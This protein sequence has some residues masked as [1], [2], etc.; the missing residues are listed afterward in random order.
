MN[1]NRFETALL[2]QCKQIGVPAPSIQPGDVAGSF[3]RDKGSVEIYHDKDGRTVAE[4][5]RDFPPNGMPRKVVTEYV[6]HE[7]QRAPD[8][9]ETV[10]KRAYHAGEKEPFFEGF[11]EFTPDGKLHSWGLIL[12][13]GTKNPVSAIQ[14]QE[15]DSILAR[16]D[17]VDLLFGETDPNMYFRFLHI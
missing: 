4:V 9:S 17:Y 8:G 5:V 7:T 15:I 16:E 13:D 6:Q 11:S 1:Y 14:T 2:D 12:K 3:S 10:I